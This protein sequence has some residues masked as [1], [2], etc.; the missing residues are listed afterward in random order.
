MDMIVCLR[1][2]HDL[3]AHSN[4]QAVRRIFLTAAILLLVLAACGRG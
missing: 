1:S 2:I 3:F 4:T